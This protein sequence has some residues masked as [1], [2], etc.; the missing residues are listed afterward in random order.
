MIVVLFTFALGLGLALDFDVDGVL[1]LGGFLFLG[2]GSGSVRNVR[3][4]LLLERE[5]ALSFVAVPSADLLG[6][7]LRHAGILL[8]LGRAASER[9]IFLGGLFVLLGNA[10]GVT[11][12]NVETFVIFVI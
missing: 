7:H 8:Y 1:G 4:F 10:T 12:S 3:Q 9:V 2:G 5:L 6:G 11:Q